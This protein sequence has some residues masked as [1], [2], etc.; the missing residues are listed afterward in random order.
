MKSFLCVFFFFL[1]D[2]CIDGQTIFQIRPDVITEC[3]SIGLGRAT[4]VWNYPGTGLVQVRV[5]PA[6]VPMTGL[7][8]PIGSGDT[9]DWVSDQLLFTLV[10]STGQ[11]LARATARVKCNPFPDPIGA[12]LLSSS[13]FPLQVGNEWVYRIDSRIGTASYVTMR[14]AGARIIGDQ[15]WYSVLTGDIETLYRADAQGRIYQLDANGREILWLDPTAN[16]NPSAVLQI[17]NGRGQ[18]FRNALGNFP[19]AFGYVIM[20]PLTRETGTF[21]RGVG[22]I[23][24]SADSLT[25]SSGGFVDGL[26]LVYARI[27]G[28]IRFATP[29]LSVGLSVESNNLDVSGGNVTNC[30]VPCYFVACG[31]TPGADPPGTYKPCFQARVRLENLPV[32]DSTTLDLDLI[33]SRERS[34]YHTSATVAAGLAQP[35]SILVRQLQLYTA[36]NQPLP[37]GTYRVQVKA[38]VSAAGDIATGTIPVQVR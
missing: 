2:V 34:V 14:V 38:K 15:A 7:Q 13:Y 12:A 9:R 21:A 18:P 16:P 3:S 30:A 20:T 35:D 27:G 4:I 17:L 1:A 33:D 36:P 23:N 6:G 26:D 37:P 22:R 5:G 10:D 29:A 24:S 31:I 11:E 25:G 28:N 8:P 19:D 32:Q